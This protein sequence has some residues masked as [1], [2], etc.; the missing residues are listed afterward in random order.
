M[1][2]ASRDLA[3]PGQARRAGGGH[4]HLA[5]QGA[6]RY[7]LGGPLLVRRYLGRQAAPSRLW[8]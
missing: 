4:L 3:R 7:G 1:T 8:R 5:P 6:E 2:V